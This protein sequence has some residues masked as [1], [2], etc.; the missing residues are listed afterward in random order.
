MIAAPFLAMQA[1]SAHRRLSPKP[2]VPWTAAQI[3]NDFAWLVGDNPSN[4]LVGGQLDFL[5]DKSGNGHVGQAYAGQASNRANVSTTLGGRSVWTAAPGAQGSFSFNSTLA[6]IARNTGQ[7]TVFALVRLGENGGESYLFSLTKGDDPNRAR[8]TCAITGGGGFELGGRR[9]DSDGYQA[10]TDGNNYKGKWILLCLIYDYANGQA[11]IRVNGRETARRNDWLTPGKTS[12]TNGGTSM[13]S[14]YNTAV[15]PGYGDYA[16]MLFVRDAFSLDNIERVEGSILWERGLQADLP[17][18][19]GYKAA[20]PMAAPTA[21]EPTKTWT[22]I[23]T[24]GTDFF[25][26][27]PGRVRYGADVRW[28]EVDLPAGGFQCSSPFFGSDPASG[29]SKVCQLLV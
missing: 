12:D 23:A 7:A 25:L 6:G 3:A 15:G 22:Q 13:I 29:S 24:E 9:N 18:D 1:A 4:A 10:L 14:G 16:E 21:P 11:V 28:L 20:R 19:H 8:L 17:A 5:A 2:L 27:A 26:V